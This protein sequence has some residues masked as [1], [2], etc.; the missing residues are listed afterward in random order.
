MLRIHIG[1]SIDWAINEGVRK[2]PDPIEE[3]IEIRVRSKRVRERFSW[4]SGEDIGDMI[5]EIADMN[6]YIW[7]NSYGSVDGLI[8]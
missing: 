8:A 6:E 4:G 3:P 5:Y 2:I 1:A 7:D